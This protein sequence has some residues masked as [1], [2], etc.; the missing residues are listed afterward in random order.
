MGC[1]GV[2]ELACFRKIQILNVCIRH[3]RD[4]AVGESRRDQPSKKN[5]ILRGASL[6]EHLEKIFSAELR[7]SQSP[8]KTRNSANGFWQNVDSEKTLLRSIL[9]Y[10]NSATTSPNRVISTTTSRELQGLHCDIL[11]DYLNDELDHLRRCHRI[12]DQQRIH[13]GLEIFK[14]HH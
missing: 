10:Q 6:R 3:K 7:E 11:P 9:P 2:S 1:N 4:A 5:A 13:G 14:Q 8:V 12:T